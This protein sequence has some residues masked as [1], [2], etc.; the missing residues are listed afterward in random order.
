MRCVKILRGLTSKL[1]TRKV[2]HISKLIEVCL[3]PYVLISNLFEWLPLSRY[4]R[5]VFSQLNHFERQLLIYDQL[6]PRYAHYF[7]KIELHELVRRNGRTKY[8]IHSTNGSGYSLLI[9]PESM[10]E[11]VVREE[12]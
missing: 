7:S 11:T 10:S 2:K 1:S 8:E 4:I 3:R 6:S 12:E 5:N 9:Y